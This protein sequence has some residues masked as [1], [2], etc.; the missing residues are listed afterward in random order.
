ML[1]ERSRCFK[2]HSQ[3]APYRGFCMRCGGIIRPYGPTSAQLSL[4]SVIEDSDTMCQVCTVCDRLGQVIRQLD[5]SSTLVAQILLW[6]C[7]MVGVILAMNT[8]VAEREERVMEH[9]T[10]HISDDD[11]AAER[12]HMAPLSI[13]DDQEH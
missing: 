12:G 3:A 8:Y 6:L 9:S 11:D 7:D 1:A 10:D 2:M 13:E 4:L 5:R